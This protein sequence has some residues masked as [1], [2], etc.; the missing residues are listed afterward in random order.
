[1]TLPKGSVASAVF[2]LLPLALW[3]MYQ[4]PILNIATLGKILGVLGFAAFTYTLLLSVRIPFQEKIFGDLGNSY[5]FHQVIGTVALMM[6][7]LHPVFLAWQYF[8]FSPKDAGMFLLPIGGDI[9]KTLGVLGLYLMT[10]CIICTYYVKMPYHTWKTI[11]KFLS[12]AFVLGALHSVLIIGDIQFMPALKALFFLF[13]VA[14]VCA[15]VY[16]VLFNNIFVRRAA[17]VVTA[18]HVINN[19]FV[20]VTLTPKEKPIT[21]MPGQFAY[22]TYMSK[23]VKA[24]E[25]PFSVASAK[26]D[27]T[28]RFISKKLGD[29]TNTLPNLQ[30]GDTAMIE[31]PYGSF[32]FSRGS[33]TQC[34]IAGGIGITPFLAFAEALPYTHNATL[35][36]AIRNDQENAVAAD[37]ERLRN[38]KPNLNVVVWNSE[39]RGYLTAKD[40]LSG[41]DPASV[42]VFLC[43]PGGMVTAMREQLFSLGIPH[44][45]IHQ[46]KFS[47]L[48][49]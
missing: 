16:R 19:T 10:V 6:L 4:P 45:H 24:E 17:Y 32:S 40:A 47:M 29:F 46:E 28:L 48:P 30:I 7:A 13:L 15:I 9:P 37:L 26:P 2:L 25:H 3:F 33:T 8:T 44:H 35:V 5:R 21:V 14:G 31:G 12:V 34:W 27:G 11:H 23:S 18:V 39:K 49:N 41:F 20:D 22:V 38:A 36:Y 43:G 1:M 42:D